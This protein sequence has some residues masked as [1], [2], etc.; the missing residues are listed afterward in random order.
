M[1]AP[2]I[3]PVQHDYKGSIFAVSGFPP[4]LMHPTFFDHGVIPS[5]LSLTIEE[6]DFG[7]RLPAEGAHRFYILQDMQIRKLGGV[8]DFVGLTGD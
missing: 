5:L 8:A 2:S 1:Q 4:N 6:T 7:A 3:D